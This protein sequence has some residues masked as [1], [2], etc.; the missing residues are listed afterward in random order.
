MLFLSS[1]RLI[2]SGLTSS[3]LSQDVWSLAPPSQWYLVEVS[4]LSSSL[5]VNELT[6]LSQ[7]NYDHWKTPYEHDNRRDPEIKMMNAVGQDNVNTAAVFKVLSSYP[8]NN[9]HTT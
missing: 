8:A 9:E 6:A 2:S 4:A 7:T 3:V 1:N 5:P